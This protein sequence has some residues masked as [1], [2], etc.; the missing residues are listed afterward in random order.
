MCVMRASLLS[1][2]PHRRRPPLSA[3]ILV[4]V[5]CLT[6]ETLAGTYL[7]RFSLVLSLGVLFLV[8]LLLIASVWGLA[9]G[10]AMA[11]TST[12]VLDYFLL[13]PAWSLRLTRSEDLA[14][15]GVFMALALLACARAWVSRL[16]AVEV[17]SREEAVLSAEVAR[18][19]LRTPELD[20]ALPATA[21]RLARALGLPEA[22]LDRGASLP[23]NQH[24]TNHKHEEGVLATLRVPADLP[25]PVIRRLRDRVVPSLEGLLDAA[26]E[27]ERVADALR[28][29]RD[30]LARIAD[31]QAALRRLA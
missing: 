7:A 12:I 8:G 31:A 16:L 13:P 17:E 4:A 26:R 5:L 18:L 27:R 29:S 1:V 24:K 19:G 25:R 3:G 28:D 23:D 2:W 9:L 30:E 6:V 20:A 21:R 11:V 15:L 22:A 10:M 14:I